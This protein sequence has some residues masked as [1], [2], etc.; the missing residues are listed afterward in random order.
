MSVEMVVFLSGERMISPQQWQEAIRE[1][2]F[3]LE[4]DTNFDLKEMNGFLPCRYKGQE[5]GFEFGLITVADA[6]P[7]ADVLQQIGARDTA[8]SF[9]THSDFRDLMASVI[10]SGVL[11][12]RTE[13]VLYDT[14]A[15]E[16]TAWPE[17]IA[18]S[19]TGENGIANEL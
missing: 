13:G 8:A 7:T 17:A 11:C 19:K 15:D 1:T 9:I 3:E 2:G 14:E 6:E 4:L 5:C 18:W 10:A 16:F 12:A